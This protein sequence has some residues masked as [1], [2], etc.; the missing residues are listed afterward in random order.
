MRPPY[1]LKFAKDVMAKKITLQPHS[2]TT[3]ARCAQSDRTK[4]IISFVGGARQPCKLQPQEAVSA[5]LPKS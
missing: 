4:A 1:W 5:I 2:Q 3:L